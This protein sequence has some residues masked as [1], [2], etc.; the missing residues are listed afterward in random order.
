MKKLKKL[1][2]LICM[3]SC[4][5]GCAAVLLGVGAGVGIGAYR[6]VEGQ[7][8]REYPLEYSRAWDAVNSALNNLNISISS[9]MND[10]DRGTIEAVRKDG[11]KV[12]V[13]LTDKRQGVTSVAVRVGMLGNRDAGERVHDEIARIAGIQ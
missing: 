1:F 12:V 6:W 11:T 3:V 10:G 8:V 4:L 13:K 9:S 2:A 5:Y 7:L